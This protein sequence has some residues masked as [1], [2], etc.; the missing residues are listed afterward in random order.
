MPSSPQLSE[1]LDEGAL[2]RLRELDPTGAN[3]LLQRVIHAYF[4]SLERFLP[5]LTAARS[6]LD[7]SALRKIAHTLKSSSASLGALILSG[8]CARLETMARDQQAE[9]IDAEI[10]TVLAELERVRAALTMLLPAKP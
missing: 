8:H 1:P 9:G 7:F 6:P 3:Q 10:E 2:A 4:G 5:E